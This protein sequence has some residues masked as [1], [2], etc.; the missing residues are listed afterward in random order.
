MHRK[1]KFIYIFYLF[2]YIYF[3]KFIYMYCQQLECGVL[4]CRSTYYDGFKILINFV[5]KNRMT[6]VYKKIIFK[7]AILALKIDMSRLLVLTFN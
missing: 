4:K 3:F 6:H 7:K 5:T 1:A 2:I